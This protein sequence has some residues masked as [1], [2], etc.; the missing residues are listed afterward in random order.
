VI[1]ILSSFVIFYS[2]VTSLVIYP[3]SRQA[4]SQVSEKKMGKELSE[5]RQTD[6]GADPGAQNAAAIL[7]FGFNGWIESVLVQICGVRF[8]SASLSAQDR[9]VRPDGPSLLRVHWNSRNGAVP[10]ATA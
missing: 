9:S 6:P 10:D 3:A 7:T 5:P 8:T 4:G 1:P 2:H